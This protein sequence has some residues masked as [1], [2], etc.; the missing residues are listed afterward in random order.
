MSWV[1]QDTV[2]A[3]KCPPHSWHAY[4]LSATSGH[5]LVLSFEVHL[6][7]TGSPDRKTKYSFGCLIIRRKQDNCNIFFGHYFPPSF[8]K[9]RLSL[10]ATDFLR[11]YSHLSISKAFSKHV[12][13]LINIF[14]S[15]NLTESN[16]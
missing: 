7:W 5:V 6:S 8:S 4:I 3:L 12:H 15:G 14:M 1:A 9:S 2:S 13:P 11:Q 10:L 16:Y